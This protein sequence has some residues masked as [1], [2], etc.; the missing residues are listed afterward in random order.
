MKIVH[1]TIKL[2]T[3]S[4]RPSYHDI[5]HQLNEF[6]KKSEIEDGQ[7]IITTA[8]TTCSLFF[9][10]Y[11][12]DHNF[13]GDELLHVDINNCLDKIA[14]KMT[15]ENQYLSPGPEHIKF[16]LSLSDPNYPA[17]KWVM[18]NTDAHIRSSL[19]GQFS[20]TVIIKESQLL[21]GAL[22]KIYFVDWDTLRERKRNI[23]LMAMGSTKN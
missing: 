10:E 7:L 12:H 19:F 6:I 17:E 16:G 14:P 21:L 9:D 15:S 4:G 3:V 13:Y 8:H 18:L 23:N 11:M 20:L 1:E 5:T 2:V 22:G